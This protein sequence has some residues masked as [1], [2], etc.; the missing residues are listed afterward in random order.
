MKNA[1]SIEPLVPH[2]EWRPAILETL[3]QGGVIDPDYASHVE[4]WLEQMSRSARVIGLAG[5]QGSGKS[6]LSKCVARLAETLLGHPAI[7][8]SLDDFYLPKAERVALADSHPLLVTRGVPGTHDANWLAETI[9]RLT[10]GKSADIPLFDKGEDDRLP[11][12]SRIDPVSFV[13]IEGWCVGARAEPLSRLAVPL[14]PLEREE[15]STGDWRHW[16]N[17]ALGS[18]PYQK[19]SQVDLMIYLR[20]SDFDHVLNWRIEQEQRHN[21]GSQQMD[22]ASLKRFIAHYERISRW[23]M[24]ELP[25]RADHTLTLGADHE[26]LDSRVN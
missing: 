21:Q 13:I 18:A 17:D 2:E 25:S 11:D 6:T 1:T 22:A 14:N 4:R 8:L 9:D 26:I 23:M 3:R 20:P 10:Q 5:S 16:V 7:V 12:V 24:E 19:L 15:D